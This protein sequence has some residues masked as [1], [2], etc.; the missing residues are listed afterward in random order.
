MADFAALVFDSC[1]TGAN[2]P[3][4]KV[5]VIGESPTGSV[6]GAGPFMA[7]DQKL[8]AWIL[9]KEAT[10]T[11]ENFQDCWS[12]ILDDLRQPQAVSNTTSKQFE[13][14]ACTMSGL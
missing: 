12:K 6:G 9:Y 2:L 5:V 10:V 13:E 8:G 14:F 3:K 1:A 11:V 4:V 7:K